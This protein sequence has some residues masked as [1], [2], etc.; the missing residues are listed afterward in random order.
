[1]KFWILTV[2]IIL[3]VIG[4]CKKVALTNCVKGKVVRITCA[5][6]VI[7]ILDNDTLGV[8]GW[9]DHYGGNNIYYDNVFSTAN[10]CDLPSNLNQGDIIWFTID[11]PNGG[12]CMV[13]AMNDDHPGLMFN[14]KNISSSPC[15]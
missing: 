1:M 8:D 14:V 15:P 6:T 2:T 10:K 5:S 11:S 13:C 7:Q 4:G 3:G 12:R 9:L